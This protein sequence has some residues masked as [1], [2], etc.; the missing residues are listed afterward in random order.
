MLEYI[1]LIFLLFGI[2]L[3]YFKIADKYNIIDKPNLRSSHD[4]ITLRGGGIIFYISS[5]L[6]FLSSGF[7]YPYF[8]IGLTF[9]AVIS[10][11]D[12]LLTL[13]NKL[14]LIVHFT[15][16]LLMAYQLNV[17]QFPWFY[18]LMSFICIVGVINAYNFMDGINGMTVCYSTVVCILL[19]IVRTNIK[20]ID[21]DLIIYSL[22][23]VL[24]FG[25][26]N[27][28]IK[29]KTFAGDVGSVSIAFILLF[30]LGSLLIKSN[31]L[32]YV[33]FLVVY[34]IDSLW[35]IIIR[36][37]L[38][39]NIFE[40]HRTHLYQYL[41]N[42]VKINKLLVSFLYGIIQ[43]VIGILVI[44]ISQFEL[45]VQTFF[46]ICLLLLLSIVYLVIKRYVFKRFILKLD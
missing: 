27:F 46:T 7:N 35:T 29:A 33:L 19:L 24:V 30:C 4:S 38:G 39:E 21:L 28:R 2:E 13:S 37:F 12:D 10:F 36:L 31:N 43:L 14:R 22:I 9:M 25:V 34:G 26:F 45:R 40:A 15:S 11:L 3:Y 44:W 20:F 18:L 42:E 32:I 5:V 1:I 6:Y 16:V 23:G 41:G 17:F 8:F